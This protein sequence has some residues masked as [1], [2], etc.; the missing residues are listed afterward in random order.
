M[1]IEEKCTT[2]ST[3]RYSP[4]K[5]DA[6]KKYSMYRYDRSVHVRG[7]DA[8]VQVRPPFKLLNFNE[9]NF[10]YTQE[11]LSR[12]DIHDILISLPTM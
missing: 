2:N 4:F 12:A 5:G 3:K 7:L 10:Q 6:L 11:K 1:S 8:Y 9:Y